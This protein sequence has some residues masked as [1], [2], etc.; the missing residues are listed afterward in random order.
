MNTEPNYIFGDYIA[1]L[2]HHFGNDTLEGIIIEEYH[3]LKKLINTAWKRQE[4]EPYMIANIKNL[5]KELT[6]E[7]SYTGADIRN[8]IPDIERF[9]CNEGDWELHHLTYGKGYK[10]VEVGGKKIHKFK[11]IEAAVEAAKKNNCKIITATNSGFTL[12]NGSSNDVEENSLANYKDGMYSLVYKP[13]N[14]KVKP[15][16]EEPVVEEVVEPA[17]SPEFL[18]PTPEPKKPTPPPRKKKESPKPKP[19]PAHSL[20]TTPSPTP[21]PTPSSSG[22]ELEVHKIE[23]KDRVLYINND[24]NEVYDAETSELL[25][26]LYVKNIDDNDEDWIIKCRNEDEDYCNKFGLY[27]P[28]KDPRCKD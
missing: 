27:E 15:V 22:D 2:E 23:W 17:P 19:R 9:Y 8:Q 12:R 4:E 1:F 6:P 25:E 26:D 13:K 18:P 14:K 7:L 5:I 28:S 10:K 24:T 20:S 21:S 16:V 11:T 3:S